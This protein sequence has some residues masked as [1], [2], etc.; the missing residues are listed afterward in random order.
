MTVRTADTGGTTAITRT[1]SRSSRS[2][3]VRL[4]SRL[5]A[6]A[7]PT[8]RRAGRPT[9]SR[10]A[11]L[12][13]RSGAEQV[14]L[15][16]LAARRGSSPRSRWAP[17]GQRRGR[18]MGARWPS[19]PPAEAATGSQPAG[20]SWP[21]MRPPFTVTR[22]CYRVDGQGYLGGRAPAPLDRGGR[23]R[24]AATQLTDGDH[25]DDRRPAWS[26]DGR[27][28][29]FVSNRDD[30][31]L[32]EF[33]SA[34]WTVPVTRRGASAHQPRRPALP[35]APGWSP[36]GREVAY[37]GLLPGQAFAPNHHVLLAAGG[38]RARRRAP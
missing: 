16:R 6:G 18:P 15:A 29:A 38:R 24:G 4:G 37:I 11:F 36:D 30:E 23:T 17:A 33:R 32:P 25:A 27:R 21:P 34:V 7:T 28:I 1:L 8:T 26:P 14:W 13:D 2:T 9:G 20:R 31:R 22:I 12:S 10:L 19:S 5:P 3:A 35:S